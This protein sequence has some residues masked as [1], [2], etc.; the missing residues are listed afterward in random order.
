MN[1]KIIENKKE[2]IIKQATKLF[3]QKG[4]D[5]TSIRDI[6]KASNANVALISYYWGGKK[7]LY[8]YIIDT[9]LERQTQYAKSFLDF[10]IN[11][12]DLS[13]EELIDIMFVAVDKAIDFFY[14]D[15]SYELLT[16]IMRGQKDVVK[17]GQVPFAKYAS[18]LL[19][20]LLD[21]KENDHEVVFTLGSI[22]SQI[23]SPRL[24]PFFFINL[25][26]QRTFHA[27]DIKFIKKNIRVYLKGILREKGLLK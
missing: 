9:L 24:L 5:G 12:E 20:A 25:V 18:K 11:P 8:E 22:I 16:N 1:K 19:A 3:A 2:I 21:K 13:K 26:G 10:A 14:R 17:I 15:E 4:F 6:C 27:S 7:E 23:Y